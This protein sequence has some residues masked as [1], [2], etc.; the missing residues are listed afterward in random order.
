MIT[1]AAFLGILTTNIN[2]A[3]SNTVVVLLFIL[4]PGGGCT[5]HFPLARS[6]NVFECDQAQ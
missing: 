6:G 5:S 2:I 4:P 1:N 3:I